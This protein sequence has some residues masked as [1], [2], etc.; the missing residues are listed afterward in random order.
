VVLRVGVLGPVMA[1]NNDEELPV[2]Q[3]RQQA[4]L[5]ILAM[6]ANR[7]IS[8]SEL[9]DAVW[10]QDPPS[11]A[12]GGVYTYVAG[13]RRIFEPG[14]SLRG[15]G[16]ILVSSSAGYVLHLVPSQ[17]DAVAFEQNLHRARQ[18]RKAGD[19]TGVAGTLAS[20]L[21]LWR[22]VA[23]AGVPGPFADTERARLGELK[24]A[25]EEE[26]ADALIALGRHE[27]V[28]ADLTAMVAEHPLR[29]RMRA[30]LMM[31]MYRSGRQAEAVRVYG[32]GRKVLAE[33]LGINPG[34]ELARIHQ[35][36][37]KMDPGLDLAAAGPV[38]SAVSPAAMSGAGPA[39]A[40]AAPARLPA[41][42]PG[43][44][45]RRAELSVLNS[46]LDD[47]DAV[48]VVVISGTA[49]VGKTA[50]AIRFGRQVARRFPDGQLYV[51]LRG[52]DPSLAPAEPGDALHFILGALGVLP[53]R[54]PADVE[55]RA[56][57]Y[58]SLA[59]GKRLLVVLDNATGAAQVRPLL[60]GSPDC[61][62]VVTSRNELTGLVAADGAR[63]LS[64]DVL[65]DDEAY[66]MLDRRLGRDQVL[67][68]QEAAAQI[69]EACA[70]LPLALSIAVG[71]AAGR[72]KR[73]LAE[74]AVELREA[75]G[76]L[77]ALDDDDAATDVR[78]VFSWSY[79]QLSVP[80][81]RMFRL[82]GV[83]PAADISLAAAASLAGLPRAQAAAALREL[84]RTHMVAEPVH[85]RYTFHDL[86]R[87]YAA[88]LGERLD[89]EAD[90][91]AAAHRV[92]DHYLQSA[93][94]AS[95][96]FR[97]NRIS[98]RPAPPLPGV[99]PVEVTDKEQA[100]A[101]YSAEIPVLLALTGYADANGFDQY[102]WLIPW[103]I[104]AYLL[105]TGRHQDWVATQW[106]A[107]AAARRLGDV[108][109]QAHSYYY[110]GF[111]L[112]SM[113]DN[114]AAEPN[115]RQS[116]ALFRELGDRGHEAMVLNGL[117]NM[118]SEQDRFAEG[119]AVAQ[120]GLRMVKAA[121]Y[122]WVQATLEVTV[123]ELYAELGQY[124]Q[125]LAHCQ[126][127]L[128]LQRESGHRAGAGDALN[129]LGKIYTRR[130]D[131]AEAKA[132]FRQAMDVYRDFSAAFDEAKAL[133]GLGKALAAEGELAE[134]K[135]AWLAAERILQRL[136]HPH[137]DD[138]RALLAALDAS[139][140]AG[141]DQGSPSRPLR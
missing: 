133:T 54:M 85:G 49:G 32:E 93:M 55:G 17:P 34:A 53:G 60:P 2:G 141:Q 111:A 92:L 3:P 30:L 73:S 127:G 64:L 8:R 82:L 25:A 91:R 118:L 51:N 134:A 96:K 107:V 33:E 16:R 109:G 26:K 27:E 65:S 115:V 87:A 124:D 22:G 75:R 24:S 66:E 121:G 81:A 44:S 122:W 137:V 83:H 101:W 56:A 71:R 126:R 86:L 69:I 132:H 140:L 114:A 77:D 95:A 9:V 100:L 59:D 112:S 123:G 94:S 78:A 106:V 40:Q 62:V 43:F 99:S 97:S 79:D 131:Y 50:L 36:V 42:A 117:A 12:E 29:E 125:A 104:A 90:R 135:D 5:A 18:L 61:L 119:L 120:D 41:D 84:V 37:L 113:G 58:R 20:A 70:R 47:R 103:A 80:A 48:P 23:L 129:T 19:L 139:E 6:R 39:A 136:A 89:S 45:G 46:L 74:V 7:V 15:P 1:W 35:Q 31:A 108:V 105:R 57:L 102:A 38:T 130:G 11:S 13:L 4:V 110:L 116:L 67:A 76:G 21:G 68:E 52:F 128:G 63:P 138:V 72:P 88:D 10:G 28:L 98:P 14:R